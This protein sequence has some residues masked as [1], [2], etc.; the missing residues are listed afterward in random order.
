MTSNDDHTILNNEIK[1]KL[2]AKRE[3][4]RIELRKNNIEE[5]MN[6]TR[7]RIN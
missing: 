1:H 2:I 7:N 5:L 4:L 3:A 6:K